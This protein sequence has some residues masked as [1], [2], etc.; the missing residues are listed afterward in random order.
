MKCTGTYIKYFFEHIFCS[1]YILFP[2]HD[3]NISFRARPERVYSKMWMLTFAEN[4][5]TS[6][7]DHNFLIR[8]NISHQIVTH[9]AFLQVNIFEV[10]NQEDAINP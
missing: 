9:S 5:V 10:V 1:F 2:W 7:T 3:V 4:L 6:I 8:V